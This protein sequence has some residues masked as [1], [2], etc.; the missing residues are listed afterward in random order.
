MSLPKK[1]I[2]VVSLIVVAFGAAL[3]TYIVNGLMGHTSPQTFDE[4]LLSVANETNKSLPMMIDK[5]TRLDATMAVAG[6]RFIY[7]Y[8]LVNFIKGEVDTSSLR[9]SIEPAL[10]DNYK[11]NPQMKQFRDEVVELHYQYKDKKGESLLEIVVNP[12]AF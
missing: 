3:G 8:T 9:K 5:E 6:K 4:T 1:K 11:S 10:I 2:I 12:S 7:S